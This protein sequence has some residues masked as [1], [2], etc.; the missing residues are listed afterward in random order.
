MD[1]EEIKQ[2]YEKLVSGIRDYFSKNNFSKAVIGISG[3][4]DSALSAKLVVDAIGKENV[5]GLI[6]P[7]KGLSSEENIKDAVER[8]KSLLT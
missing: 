4:I 1:N 5:H 6:M 3:G 7:L 2:I 8:I